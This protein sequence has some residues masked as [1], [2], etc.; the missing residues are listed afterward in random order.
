MTA[1]AKRQRPTW[2]KMIKYRS[3]K[4]QSEF[5]SVE[6]CPV[7]FKKTHAVAE[8][9]EREHGIDL[10][11]TSIGRADGSSHDKRN[12]IQP[13][14]RAWDGRVRDPRTMKRAI[15][16]KVVKALKVFH[17]KKLKKHGRFDSLF[18]HNVFDKKKNRWRGPHIHSQTPKNLIVIIDNGAM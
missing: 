1:Q 7:L 4:E 9:L 15:P 10:L 17:D 16:V 12:A 6:F 5:N 14:F 8:Y 3:K 18:E 11:I 13:R 2:I